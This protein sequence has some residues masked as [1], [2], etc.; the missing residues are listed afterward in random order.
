MGG[1][2]A[3]EVKAPSVKVKSDKPTRTSSRLITTTDIF[4]E[5][6]GMN[7]VYVVQ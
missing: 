6:S 4:N 3:K 5:S 7:D 2:Q 1:Q